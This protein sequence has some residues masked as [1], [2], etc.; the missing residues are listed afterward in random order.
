MEVSET[1][2]ERRVLSG[3]LSSRV[4]STL[5]VLSGVVAAVAWGLGDAPRSSW[6]W[7]YVVLLPVW[8]VW[9]AVAWRW[10]IV[11]DEAGVT[12]RPGI[13]R[14]RRVTW[15]RVEGVR[16]RGWWSPWRLEVRDGEDLQLGGLAGP[17][18]D[19][20]QLQVLDRVLQRARPAVGNPGLAEHAERGQR[21]VRAA[22]LAA[23]AVCAVLAVL[24]GEGGFV[25]VSVLLSLVLVF[26]VVRDRRAAHRGDGAGAPD[27]GAPGAG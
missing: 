4:L 14:T 25:A 20:R 10:R 19:G 11:L 7:L 27:D 23:V 22:F 16:R 21:R 1:V 17:A 18:P 6:P 15:D 8:A 13:G 12:V 26:D 3:S 24:T 5:A 2:I 9:T